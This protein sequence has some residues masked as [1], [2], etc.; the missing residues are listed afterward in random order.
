MQAP[1]GWVFFSKWP[2]TFHEQW[3]LLTDRSMLVVKNIFMIAAKYFGITTV[4]GTPRVLTDMFMAQAR[5]FD[6]CSIVT[7]VH[8][9][10]VE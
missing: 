1:I 9:T 5:R 6:T 3:I 4:I 7:G 2:G 8:A 10:F